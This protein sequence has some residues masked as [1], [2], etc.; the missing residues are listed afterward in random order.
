MRLWWLLLLPIGSV[1]MAQGECLLQI[2]GKKAVPLRSA[3][4]SE[5]PV[6]RSLAPK[7]IVQ[8]VRAQ[9]IGKAHWLQVNQ[10]ALGWLSFSSV[11]S[12]CGETTD[13]QINN[14][15]NLKVRGMA[16]DIR[17]IEKLAYFLYSGAKGEIKETTI[18]AIGAITNVNAVAVITV[19]DNQV[20]PVRRAVLK[21]L[22]KTAQPQQTLKRYRSD[23][24]TVKTWQSLL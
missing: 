16:G 6:L 20:E 4:S 22:Q 15:N 21:A 19:L 5:S 18:E 24:P 2:G 12:F 13:S 3:P 23:S 9:T 1:G 14:V 10:P 8:P 11:T 7:T 17:A